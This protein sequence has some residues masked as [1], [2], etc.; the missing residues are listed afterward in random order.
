[1]G[2]G[3]LHDL[4]LVD[5]L[6]GLFVRPGHQGIRLL[7]GLLHHGVR[8]GLGLPENGVLLADNLLVLFDLIGD[9]QT[10]LNQ[11]LLQ[12]LLVHDDLCIG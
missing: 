11:E 12:L 1:M 5:H 4:V 6:A 2:V 3:P 7:F 10:Q 8:L 9:A